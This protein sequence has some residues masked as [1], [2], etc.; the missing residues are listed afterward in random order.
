M[1]TI[2]F[3]TMNQP[4]FLANNLAL[5]FVN[6]EYG[7]SDEHQDHLIDDK[8]TVKWLKLAGCLPEENVEI[9]FGLVEKAKDLRKVAREVIKAAIDG[10]AGNTDFINHL[11][12]KGSPKTY[13]QWDNTLNSF[14][15]VKRRRDNSVE[16]LLEPI[17][18]SVANLICR[19]ELKYVRQCEAH[20]CT[21]MFLDTTK[22]HRRRWC[23]MALCGNRMKVAAFRSRR[24]ET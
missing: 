16:S 2:N 10:E 11:L 4:Q 14:L 23:S 9:P 19:P 5:D 21:L 1:V 15:L 8:S 3:M 6:S 20:D 24:N 22:S 7:M 12:D 17:A 18:A 13:L